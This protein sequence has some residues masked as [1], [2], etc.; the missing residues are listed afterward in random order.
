MALA[1]TSRRRTLAAAASALAAIALA[2][3][4]VGRGCRVGA[5]GPDAAVRGLL[6]AARAGDR[7]AVFE[8]LSPATQQRL[9]DRARQAT[10]LVG[11]SVRYRPLDLIS[12]GSFDD[13]PS[14]SDLQVVE[15][16]GERA[17]VSVETSGGTERIGLVKV[18]GRWR[19][20]L[21]GY[22]GEL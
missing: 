6:Q 5:P 12:I 10:A 18:D 8:L 21:A 4:V 20:D 11:A 19:I 13:A 3:G 2:V 15:D 14:P 22:G 7:Q 17:T 1:L 16:T 9:A